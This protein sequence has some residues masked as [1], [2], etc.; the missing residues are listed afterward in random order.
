MS[1][2]AEY[3]SLNDIVPTGERKVIEGDCPWPGEGDRARFYRPYEPRKRGVKRDVKD[4]LE[5]ASPSQ[6]A[7]FGRSK[8]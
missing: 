7:D 6:C 3:L 1:L 2:I 8:V 5:R 4:Y